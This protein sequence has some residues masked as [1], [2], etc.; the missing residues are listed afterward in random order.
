MNGSLR[1]RC[2]RRWVKSCEKSDR[3]EVCPVESS[4]TAPIFSIFGASSL[5]Y[6]RRRRPEFVRRG[7]IGDRFMPISSQVKPLG[8]RKIGLA[9]SS[10]VARGWAHIGALRALQRFGIDFDILAGCSAGALVGGC[11]L[12]RKLDELERWA[13]ALNKRKLLGYLDLNLG[14]ED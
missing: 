4:S 11:F 1:R 5:K 12:A 13:I 3:G 8:R 7:T 9:L 2:E 14:R 6:E 10:G